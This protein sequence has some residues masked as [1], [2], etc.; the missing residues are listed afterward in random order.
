MTDKQYLGKLGE[1]NTLLRELIG[2]AVQTKSSIDV[3][4]LCGC[5][6]VLETQ[7]EGLE[8]LNESPEK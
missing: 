8:T 7:I 5:L 3:A 4:G 6:R 1:M 2:E